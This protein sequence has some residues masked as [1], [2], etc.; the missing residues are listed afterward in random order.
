M[1]TILDGK[2]AAE[3]LR[4]KILSQLKNA[5]ISAKEPPC[6]AIL[7]VG[8]DPRSKPYVNNKLKTATLWG[9]NCKHVHLPRTA[10]FAEIE[11]EIEKLNNDSS[12][13]GIIFQLPPDVETPLGANEIHELLEKISPQKDADGLLSY[14]LGSLVALGDKCGTPIPATPLGILRLLE[15]YNIPIDGADVCVF[16]KSRLVGMPVSV[17]LEHRGATVTI[18]HSGTKNKEAK[19]KDADII[20]AATGVEALI[21][22]SFVSSKSVVVDV[23]I[24]STPK[25]LRG[26]VCHSVYDKIS[27]YS[28]VPGGVGPMTVA[29]LMENV[30]TLWSA[31]NSS[32]KKVK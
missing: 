1:T 20:I 19:A 24:V 26:D 8:D 16:G 7:V 9:I 27:A 2:V 23:G 18:C 29:A 21:K 10:R 28:P 14:N 22:E 32:Q 13:N 3:A 4:L 25:G 17:L 15:H 11:K 12:V 31:Q 30:I 6:L 5:N